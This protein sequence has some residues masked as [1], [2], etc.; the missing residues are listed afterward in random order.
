MISPIVPT[1]VVVPHVGLTHHLFLYPSFGLPYGIKFRT[2]ALSHSRPSVEGTLHFSLPIEFGYLKTYHLKVRDIS[3]SCT[4][5]LLP[6]KG[7]RSLT[8]VSKLV[9]ESPDSNP[10]PVL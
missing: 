7:A 5:P 6:L 3:K 1:K 4:F 10:P 8:K 2:F 9:P